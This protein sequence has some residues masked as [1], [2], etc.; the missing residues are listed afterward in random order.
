LSSER[1]E[2]QRRI[3]ANARAAERDRLRNEALSRWP[4]L[5]GVELERRTDELQREKLSAAGRK[6]RELQAEKLR[7]AEVVIASLS[8]IEIRLLETLDYIRAAY[9]QPS[10][11]V[12]A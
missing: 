2:T 3:L 12:A 9:P 11:D 7:Q 1:L 6:G 5:T 8:G 4:G 10:G